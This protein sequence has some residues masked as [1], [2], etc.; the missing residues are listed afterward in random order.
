MYQFWLID[1]SGDRTS[2]GTFS[3]DA[4]GRGW[5]LIRSP[6]P[7]NNFQSVGVTI[8]PEGGSPAPTGAKMMGTSL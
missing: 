5:V 3:V 6:K 7:L 4:Q 2:G 1:P 8:E